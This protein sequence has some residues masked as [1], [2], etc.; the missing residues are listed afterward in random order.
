MKESELITQWKNDLLKQL[1][2]SWFY[3]LPDMSKHNV[4]GFC[5]CG[6]RR[7]WTFVPRK[8]F[9]VISVINGVPVAMEWK[10]HTKTTAFPF[11]RVTEEQIKALLEFSQAGLAFLVFGSIVKDADP[12]IET[13]YFVPIKQWCVV[14]SDYVSKSIRLGELLT[15]PIYLSHR[16]SKDRRKLWGMS[17]ILGAVS[18]AGQRAQ[19]I[20]SNWV[21]TK[22][23]DGNADEF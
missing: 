8:P 1:P 2:H 22:T 15:Y 5:E 17:Q 16:E 12:P 21:E 23:V 14:L 11:N 6:R 20:Q 19:D 7:P 9:D 4:T 10:I 18:D 13:C 3:K